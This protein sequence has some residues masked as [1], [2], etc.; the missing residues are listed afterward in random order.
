MTSPAEDYRL[1]GKVMQKTGKLSKAAKSWSMVAKF[2][3]LHLAGLC[4]AVLFLG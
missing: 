2:E 1:Q 4:E 3:P